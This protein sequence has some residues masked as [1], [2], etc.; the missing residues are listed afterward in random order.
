MEITDRNVYI[1][2]AGFSAEAGVPLIH[3][4]LDSSR[5]LLDQP[6][7]ELDSLERE[8]FRRV[9]EF[10]RQ[11]AQAREKVR[12][13]LDDIE[14]LFGL[15]EISQRLEDSPRET[16]DSTVY[17]IAKTLQLAVSLGNSKRP[18]L[19]LPIETQRVHDVP[20]KQLRVEPN[21]VESPVQWYRVDVYDYFAGLVCGLFDDPK[22]RQS[23]KDTIITFN[24]DLVCD[25]AL[26]RLG[27][28]AD[29]HL[30]KAVV[31]DRRD[32]PTMGRCDLL[33]LHGST[34]WGVCSS[35]HER[36]VILP[37]KV[38]DSPIAFR[39]LRCDCGCFSAVSHSAF[40]GQ[41]RISTDCFSGLE[42]GS[43]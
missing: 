7:S 35:C 6:F 12:I 1:L 41:E 26:R 36:V 21:M 20:W 8:H 10:R 30:S 37:Q 3:G 11:M 13:D 32:A 19:G 18:Y 31:D 9:F 17:L 39:N 16:R 4:F 34:N 40:M 5:R 15:V 2:G 28:E 27:Y 24:Y 14:Q 38:T 29:Y 42:K 22:K 23:R 43:R 25:H 33:K